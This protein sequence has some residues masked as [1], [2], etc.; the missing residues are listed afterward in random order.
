M[1]QDQPLFGLGLGDAG[2]TNLA[3]LAQIKPDF[4][5]QDL[6]EAVQDLSGGEATGGR[7]E[8]LLQTHPQA[9]TQEG[10][11]DMGFDARLEPVPN[12]PDVQLAFERAKD[13]LDF[14]RAGGSSARGF[15]AR[16]G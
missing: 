14:G 6:L 2:Q 1:V 16:L 12:G 4:H 5:H 10:H 3:A 9:I 8:F 7:F 13:A 15:R 11:Q